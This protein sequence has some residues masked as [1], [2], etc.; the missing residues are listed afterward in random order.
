MNIVYCFSPTNDDYPDNRGG[1]GTRPPPPG[2]NPSYYPNTGTG[3]SDS[4]SGGSA[5]QSQGPAGG[6]F[7]TGAATGGLLGYLFGNRK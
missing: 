4:C 5:R 1:P 3:F 7:W 6:G 2:F